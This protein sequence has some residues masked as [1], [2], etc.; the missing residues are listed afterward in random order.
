MVFMSKNYKLPWEIELF[1]RVNGFTGCK[2]RVKVHP[3]GR[4]KMKYSYQGMGC[5]PSAEGLKFVDSV[6]TR[7]VSHD[8]AT[9]FAKVVTWDGEG[10]KTLAFYRGKKLVHIGSLYWGTELRDL[11]R[12]FGD[13]LR[14]TAEL[15][16]IVTFE[17]FKSCLG[18][19]GPS[20][21]KSHRGKFKARVKKHNISFNPAS[22]WCVIYGS[23]W[24]ILEQ[25]KGLFLVRNF[26][27]E[28]P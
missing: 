11:D 7:I 1:R 13:A 25:G 12:A 28:N 27:N 15:P 2:I 24:E 14:S 4:L 3:K 22:N 18:F 19:L 17:E 20:E 5:G 21:L 26:F 6:R 8:G 9:V 10:G 16:E 23:S